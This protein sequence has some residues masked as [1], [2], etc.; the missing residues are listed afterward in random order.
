MKIRRGEG[1][2]DFGIQGAWGVEHFSI[3]KGKGG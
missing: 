2:N 3:S 1:F